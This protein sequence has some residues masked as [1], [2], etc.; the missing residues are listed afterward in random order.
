MAAAVILIAGAAQPGA[1]GWQVRPA[2]W[3]GTL[4]RWTV[5]A[6][7]PAVT[8]GASA[9]TAPPSMPH[10]GRPTSTLRRRT[11]TRHRSPPRTGCA[12]PAD[13]LP[14]QDRPRT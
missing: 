1:A 6:L 8:V 5:D 4:L 2:A 7:L 10:P 9:S 13:Q 11:R 14:D 3:Y 12:L